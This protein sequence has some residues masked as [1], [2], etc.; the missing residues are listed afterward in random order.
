MS[1][2]WTMADGT[3]IKI[4][5]MTD[6]HL[7]NAIAMLERNCGALRMAYF[8]DLLNATN[9]LQ[10]EMALY[11]LDRESD[12]VAELSDE[13]FLWEMTEYGDLVSELESR[14]QGRRNWDAILERSRR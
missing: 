2:M 8:R 5:D 13:E 10:G 4:K 11:E 12:T 9:L 6:S 14:K 1:K 3:Q 7:R